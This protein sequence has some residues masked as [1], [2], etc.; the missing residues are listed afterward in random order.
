GGYLGASASGSLSMGNMGGSITAG[1]GLFIGGLQVNDASNFSSSLNIAGTLTS[2]GGISFQNNIGTAPVAT[3]A[4]N[5]SFAGLII[6]NSGK[7]DI[8]TASSSGVTRFVIQQNGSV[9]IGTATGSGRLNIVPLTDDVT[10]QD[11]LH[12]SDHTQSGY[13]FADY[14]SIGVT[15]PYALVGG[16]SNS[17]SSHVNLVLGQPGGATKV[18]ILNANPTTALDVTGVINASS[19]V[20]VNGVSVC[21]T[22]GNCAG[23]SQYWTASGNAISPS[24][25]ANVT[26]DLLIGGV[27]TASA[28]FHVYGQNKLTGG[29]TPVAS[30]AANTSYAG[31][32]VDNKGSGDLF[33]ASSSGLQRFVI[34]QNGNVRIGSTTSSTVPLSPASQLEL[35]STRNAVANPGLSA[36]Y[37]LSLW[38][39]SGNGGQGTG[40]A[41]SNTANVDNIGGS[42]IFNRA[43]ANSQGALQFY[44]K[45][46]T[47]LGDAPDLAF[48]LNSAGATASISGN[49]GFAGLVVNNSGNGDLFTASSSGQSRFTI[50]QNGNVG[51]GTTMPTEKLSVNGNIRIGPQT[52]S[53]VAFAK[54]TQAAGTWS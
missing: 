54:K 12:V 16:W 35:T 37:A 21:L 34:A 31:L 22:S 28:T 1:N 14:K 10:L 30:I 25:T 8:F 7:G 40:I 33:T 19:N 48:T 42:I 17:L 5:T 27:S 51:I 2:S 38:N 3:I 53:T 49:T 26:S 43:G 18:G 36:N 4:A 41:F 52:N 11:G 9:S 44:T 15:T 23:L 20:T 6:D 46:S 45:S 50:N 29:T 32:V 47:I 24:G 13:L 39:T